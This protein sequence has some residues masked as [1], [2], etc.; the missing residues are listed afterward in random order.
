MAIININDKIETGEQRP[1]AVLTM[2][3]ELFG[4]YE[5]A[6]R[7]WLSRAKSEVELWTELAQKLTANR[8]VPEAVA[9]YQE[10]V[11]QRM[12]MAAGGPPYHGRNAVYRRWL[13]HHRLAEIAPACIFATCCPLTLVKADVP[14]GPR[15]G[16]MAGRLKGA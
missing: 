13:S 7:A 6:S 14:C 15:R 16:H 8:S 5:E 1:E 3:K 10:C 11:A 9:A 2:Q 4:A 12:K